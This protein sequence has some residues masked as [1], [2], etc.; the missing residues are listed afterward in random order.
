MVQFLPL[1]LLNNGTLF[2]GDRLERAAKLAHPDIALQI[3][4]DSHLADVNDMARGPENF[5]KVVACGAAVD[6]AGRTRAYRHHH[7]WPARQ[8]TTSIRC[9][10]GGVVGGAEEDHLVR[11]IVRRARADERG[12]GVQRPRARHP[13]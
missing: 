4:L 7:R 5:A 8:P 6:R 10:A 12:L 1:V 13:Q 11:P 9:G 3:S 2:V